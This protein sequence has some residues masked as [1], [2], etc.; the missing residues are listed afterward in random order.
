LGSSGFGSSK[1]QKFKGS[2]VHE[3]T[4]SQVHGLRSRRRSR[5][6]RYVI[7]TKEE[8]PETE[9]KVKVKVKV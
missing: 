3:F 9:G 1:V 7:P 8:S 4:S 6:R 5:L 2:K